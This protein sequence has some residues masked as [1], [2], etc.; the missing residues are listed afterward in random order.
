MGASEAGI[1]AAVGATVDA[2]TAYFE[3]TLESEPAGVAR[4]RTQGVCDFAH[5][6]EAAHTVTHVPEGVPDIFQITD[7]GLVYSQ[8]TGDRWH[9]LDVGGWASA[10]LLSVLGWLYGVVDAAAGDSGGHTVTMSAQRAVEACPASLRDELRTAFA[11]AGH[12]DAVATGWLRTDASNRVTEC[13]LELPGGAD[14]LFGSAD[15]GSRITLALSDFGEPASITPP[16]DA[17]PPV[18][19]AEYIEQILRP[20]E[21]RE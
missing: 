4:L 17:G 3:M 19:M 6:R 21:E 10:G 16:P 11:Q 7:G 15:I 14:G 13:R 18:P 12:H 20:E 1:R 5:Q 2:G 8:E 9:V